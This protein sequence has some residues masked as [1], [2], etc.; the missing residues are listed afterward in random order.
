MAQF[1]DMAESLLRENVTGAN[2]A[3]FSG[4]KRAQKHAFLRNEPDSKRAK[5]GLDC[6][7]TEWVATDWTGFFNPVRLA[8]NARFVRG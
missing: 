5:M 2:G 4:R 1:F 7:D 8:R 6:I 3:V